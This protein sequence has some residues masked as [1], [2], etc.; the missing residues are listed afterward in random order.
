M[1]FIA[2]L[3]AGA[4]GG[5]L[6]HGLAARGRVPDVR[7]IDPDHSI[8]RG[9]ALDILQSAAVEG[10]STRVSASEGIES[11]A[12]AAAVVIADAAVSGEEHGGEPGLALLRRLAALERGAP[13][14]FAG[15]AQRL[16]LARSVTELHV[17]PRRL[18]GSA[19][20]ALESA[21]RAL[22]ALELDGT[23]VEV[24]LRVVGTPPHAAV[25]AWEEATAFGLPVSSLV[26]AHRLAAISGR[27]PG[28]WPPGPYA[29]AS[30]AA[31]LA[32]AVVNGSRRRFTCFVSLE[33]APNRGAVTA[34]PA[35][36]GPQGIVRVLQPALT[37]Q[38]RT[39]L[40]NGLSAS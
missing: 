26:P 23:G 7:L 2:I 31:R 32:E 18:M 35:E 29:L 22:T 14:I 36:V 12:G 9:K 5:A 39:R 21:V 38:E 15:A 3:G 30:A 27:V 4:I 37:R 17:R 28:L 20:A 34:L 33:D 19:P 16:V 10:F 25:I 8:A 40:E 24:Q 11:A 1:S 6:A 13:I